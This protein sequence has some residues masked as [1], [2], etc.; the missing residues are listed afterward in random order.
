M[1]TFNKRIFLTGCLMGLAFAATGLPLSHQE[2]AY[3]RE[4]KEIVFAVQPSFAP[5]TFVHQEQVTGLDVEL[6]RWMATETGFRPRFIVAPL[7][8]ALDKLRTGEVDAM[9]S[10]AYSDELNAEFSFTTPTKNAPVVLFVQADCDDISDLEDLAQANVAILG[11]SHILDVLVRRKIQ[12]G[13]K[14]VAKPEDAL[15]LIESGAV[16]AVIGNELV[17]QHYLY[18]SGKGNLKPVGEPLF[19][20]RIC[21][22][23]AEGGDILKDILNKGISNAQQTGILSRIQAKW[24]GSEYAR[25]SLPIR[26]IITVALVCAVIGLTVLLLILI[27]N[28]RLKRSVAE[29]TRLYVESEKRLRDIFDNSPDAIFV[30]N[31]DGQITTANIQAC[32]LV[33]MDQPTLLSKSVYD[34]APPEWHEEVASNMQLWFSGQLQQCEGF[35]LASDGTV[36]PIEMTGSLHQIGGREML[37]LRARDISLRKKAEQDMLTAKQMAEE[38]KELA[39]QARQMAERASQAKSEFL[40]NMSHEIRTPLNGILGMVQLLDDTHLTPEQKGFVDTIVQSSSSLIKIISHVLDISKIEAGQMDLRKSVIDLHSLCE[41]LYHMFQP[42]AVQ[43]GVDLQCQC[44]DDIPRHVIGDEGLLEQVLVNLIGNALKFTHHGSVTLNIEC[45][46]RDAVETELYFQ[47]IDTGIGIDKQAKDIIFEKFTQVDGSNKRMYGGT[48]LGLAICKKLIELM[49]GKIG[50]ISS[51]G[52]GSTFHFN[53]TMR[54]ADP[55][56]EPDTPEP[57]TGIINPDVKVLLAEDNKVNQ[58]VAIAILQKAG[59][60][61][62]AVENGQDAIHR[63][64]Q[65]VYD[66]VLMDCQMPVMD[67]FEATARIRAMEDPLC[68]IPIIAITAHAMKEDQAKCLENGM[69]DY[70]SKPVSRQNLIDVINK[71]TV[72]Q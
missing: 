20:A 52:R 43:S 70:I 11:T 64:Q 61:V 25:K 30:M 26:T 27:W 42:L 69:D 15:A 5:F 41:N 28:R 21:M 3:L 17:V 1:S 58:K 31:R 37:Q 36:L 9:L 47:V 57:H 10:L 62:D 49:G 7:E 53:L 65:Q 29:Q 45:H 38:A 14:F 50:L 18:S 2:Q 68:R 19:S 13:I 48:G 51:K 6:V 46:R 40:A 71:H 54:L 24:L 4:K 32:R 56:A 55:P 60:K 34:L 72:R 59:C 63:I 33:K 66:V 8:E 67:G 22:A 23:V 35:S 16:D 44:R 39:E 12:C